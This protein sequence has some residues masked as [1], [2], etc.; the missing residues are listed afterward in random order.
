MILARPVA[1]GLLA[2][3]LAVLFTVPAALASSSQ[4][5]GDP[6]PATAAQTSSPTTTAPCVGEDC[7]PNP[8]TSAPAP[9]GPDDTDRVDANGG[10]DC[11]T[12]DVG[13][14]IRDGINAL[15]Q[16]IVDAALNPLLR[17][18]SDTL[19]TTPTLADLPQVGP[20]WHNSWQIVIAA[21][22]TLVLIAGILLMSYESLQTRYTIK[23][24]LPRLVIGFLAAF[25]SLFVAEKAIRLANA[26]SR[27][28]LS[29]G[30]DADPAGNSLRDMVT[31]ALSGGGLF[32]LLLGL[33]LAVMLVAL[34][35]TY[36][37]RI[38]I[39]VIL[40][41]GAPLALMCHALPQ[42]E[43]IAKW[44]W[45]AFGG[46]LAIQVAQ[47]LTLLVALR[48]FFDPSGF[49]PFGPSPSGLV[50]LLVAL[51]MVYIL[52][53]IPLWIL[54]ATRVSGGRS[55]AGSVVRGWIAYKTFGLLTGNAGGSP[56]LAN[57]GHAPSA[58]HGRHPAQPVTTAPAAR[59][60]TPARAARPT[61]PPPARPTGP[62]TPVP[63][64]PAPPIESTPWGQGRSYGHTPDTA[65][66][67]SEQRGQRPARSGGAP[68]QEAPVTQSR[69]R[70]RA[71]RAR[72]AGRQAWQPITQGASVTPRRPVPAPTNQP[73]PRRAQRPTAAA[74]HANTALTPD[75]SPSRAADRFARR[76]PQSPI[77]KARRYATPGGGRTP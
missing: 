65:Y 41:I 47:S 22:S 30:L 34:L 68:H 73:T 21:Y 19:L 24:L 54:G 2:I 70:D 49:T 4:P 59:V 77:F 1:S 67:R 3:A 18:L 20:L 55:L 45:K 10:E 40:L 14:H 31:G 66:R 5:S 75:P 64:Q 58:A 35:I 39:T 8:A 52:L 15:F 76:A 53:K 57:R 51:A 26:L 7:I 37:V 69:S 36:I 50:N 29:D 46:V 43:G 11:G 6:R 16:G 27:A 9:N 72:E 61:P 13:C 74:S 32:L 62:Y 71:H 38:A 28:L 44:W 33:A 17:L 48:V 60:V 63:T 23:E 12:F 25:L 42:T 56:A